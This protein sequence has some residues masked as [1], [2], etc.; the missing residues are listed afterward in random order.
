MCA[1]NVTHVGTYEYI[2]KTHARLHARMQAPAMHPLETFKKVLPMLSHFLFQNFS[3]LARIVD[4]NVLDIAYM[5]TVFLCALLLTIMFGLHIATSQKSKLF[6]M[7]S[8]LHYEI[9][10]LFIASVDLL[11]NQRKDTIL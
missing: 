1:M 3:L 5:K 10:S 2:H 8:V 6:I 7:I 4:R 11:Y 9:L